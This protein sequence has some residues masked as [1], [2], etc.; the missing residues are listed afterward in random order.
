[1]L[2]ASRQRFTATRVQ[3]SCSTLSRPPIWSRSET[4]QVCGLE[5]IKYAIYFTHFIQVLWEHSGISNMRFVMW[6]RERPGL[7]DDCISGLKPDTQWAIG[8]SLQLAINQHQ[9]ALHALGY[10]HLCKDVCL[11]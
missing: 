10:C 6:C 3:W 7:E 2:E 4:G 1:M 8:F 9:F 5:I 11:V